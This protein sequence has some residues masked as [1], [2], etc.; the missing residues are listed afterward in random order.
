MECYVVTASSVL[1]KFVMVDTIH[2][3]MKC[4]KRNVMLFTSCEQ[5][6]HRLNRCALLCY[7]PRSSVGQYLLTYIYWMFLSMSEECVSFYLSC[8]VTLS[9]DENDFKSFSNF[10]AKS[11]VGFFLLQC[12]LY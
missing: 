9:F 6:Q 11:S 7:T 1:Y 8:I 5:A 12:L 10:S 3:A 4:C 2:L